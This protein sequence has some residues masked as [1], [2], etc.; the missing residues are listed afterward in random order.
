[1]LPDQQSDSALSAG[2]VISSGIPLIP[3]HIV[4]GS[5]TSAAGSGVILIQ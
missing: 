1:M 4:L 3:G 2:D 5:R